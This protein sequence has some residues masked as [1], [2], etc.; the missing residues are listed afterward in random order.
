MSTLSEIGL[1]RRQRVFAK[2]ETA[3]GEM[4]FPSGTLDF[5]RPAGNASITQNPAFA[6]SEELANT[7][8]VLDQFQGATPA[9]KWSLVMYLRPTGTLGVAQRMQGSCLLQSLQG[10]SLSTLTATLTANPGATAATVVIGTIASSQSGGVLPENGVIKIV[11]AGGGGKL[12]YIHYTG[13]TRVLRDSTTATLTGCTRG[14]NSSTAATHTAAN[15]ITLQSPFYQQKTT[16]PTFSLWIET[17]HFVQGLSGCSVETAA[18][19]IAVEGG[20]KLTMDGQGMQMVY[21]GSSIL[22]ASVAATAD[23]IHVTDASL[24]SAGA[25]IYDST[26]G[27]M[28]RLISSVDTSAN[29]ISLSTTVQGATWASGNTIRGFLPPGTEIGDPIE[30]KDTVAKVS[31]VTAKIKT[32]SLSFKTPKKYLEDEIGTDYPEDFMEDKRD[33]TS[34]LSL[35]FR[36][37]DAKYFTDGFAGE[38]VPVLVTFGDTAGS[39]LDVYMKR[40]KLTVPTIN[41]ASPAVELSIPIKALGI[42]GEDSAEITVR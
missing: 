37:A 26:A 27:T 7:L 20:V 4:I 42:V 31:G 38:E 14:Y 5:I 25:Y 39:I 40:C 23:H 3:V 24:F 16:S 12:E 11:E 10:A 29:T 30:S 33:I 19:D 34:T 8:D 41:Y 35:Y 13:I 21:A 17:D 2:M 6:D 9:G 22:T 36:K 15:V 1:A 28:V 32:G 18:F